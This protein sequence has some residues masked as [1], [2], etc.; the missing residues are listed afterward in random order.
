MEG[1]GEVME[2]DR[3]YYFKLGAEAM[4]AEIA[5]RL[6]MKGLIKESIAVLNM[7]LPNFQVP[8][9]VEVK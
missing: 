7:P 6:S 1:G 5:V 9:T 3:L 2:K 8:E 4:Q